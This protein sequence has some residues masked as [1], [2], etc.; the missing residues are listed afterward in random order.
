MPHHV[1]RQ[2]LLVPRQRGKCIVIDCYKRLPS[3]RKTSSFSELHLMPQSAVQTRLFQ[4]N[5]FMLT[6]SLQNNYHALLFDLC[7]HFGSLYV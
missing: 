6:C 3:S 5:T 2:E 4:R 7:P 1:L